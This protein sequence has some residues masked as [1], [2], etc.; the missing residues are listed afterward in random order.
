MQQMFY[1]NVE[2]TA[3]VKLTVADYYYHN[4]KNINGVGVIPD[5]EVE[6]DEAVSRLLVIPV[7]Q[8]NQLQK[9]IETVKAE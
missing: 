8:D 9:A 6:L 5:V 7:E 3:A 1:T 4:D 2:K